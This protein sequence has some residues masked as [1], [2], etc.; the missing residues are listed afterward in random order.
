MLPEQHPTIIEAMKKGQYTSQPL[1][2]EIAKSVLAWFYERKGEATMLDIASIIEKSNDPSFVHARTLRDAIY[3]EGEKRGE[4]KGEKKGKLEGIKE[5]EKKGEK[6]GERKGRQAAAIEKICEC[7]RI[8]FQQ[9]PADVV[10][11]IKAIGDEATLS[12][13]FERC[14]KAESLAEIEEFLKKNGK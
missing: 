4:E 2:D 9:V 6:K 7:L 8:R 1:L 14:I 13:L 10:R 12:A 3:R 5:G 11:Q